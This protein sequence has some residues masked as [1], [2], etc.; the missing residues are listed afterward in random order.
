M[1][2]Y[3][4][5][6]RSRRSEGLLRTCMYEV[7]IPARSAAR[8]VAL[9]IL[10]ATPG[11]AAGQG[12]AAAPHAVQMR[13][14]TVLLRRTLDSLAD[15]HR[16]V[17][18]YSVTNLETGERLSRRGDEP[19]SSAS[20]I[21][22]PVL[23]TLFELIEHD[24]LSLDDKLTMLKI[25][26]VGGSGTLQHM[27][28]GLVLTVADAASLMIVVS[29][30]T[31]TNLIVDRIAARRVWRKMEALGLPRTKIHGRSM[32]PIARVDWDSGGKYGLGVTT[33]NEMAR[34]FELLARGQAVSPRADSAMLAI[35]ERTDHVE[36]MQRYLAGRRAAYKTG[37][38]D[39]TRAE[40]SLWWLPARVVA[41]VMTREN[42]DTRYVIDTEAHVTMGRMAEAIVRAWTPPAAGPPA[43]GPVNR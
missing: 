26:Q 5:S 36:M 35:L 43:L 41:C 17:V 28:P 10:L 40:C 8:V 21:K 25:D 34:L 39:R 3:R 15:A 1:T 9:I 22:V 24:S 33:P 7:G 23:V 4:A 14:D 37:S 32:N 29:D 20:L 19:F 2:G 6:L 16:G 12:G 38:V 31:A 27:R 13:A 11:C 18:G 42:E 30:N